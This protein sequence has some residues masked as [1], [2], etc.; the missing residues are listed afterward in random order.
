MATKNL[1]ATD[2]VDDN[3]IDIDLS[4]IKKQKFRINGDNTKILELNTS[5]M[6]LVTRLNEAYP[7]LLDLQNKVVDLA[8]VQ[9]GDDDTELLS[10]TAT[11]LD[12]IDKEM[13]ELLDYIFNSN[14]SEVC[15]SEGSMFDPID[16]EFRYEHIISTLTKLYEHD[17][18]K[19]FEQMKKRVEKHT[20][21]YTKKRT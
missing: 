9:D 7:K 12:K 19:E 20:S 14:V 11:K 10:A 5:D 15:G 21:K 8:D 13:R 3:I 6:G 2:V 18:N 1:P 4:A 17:M 16:G